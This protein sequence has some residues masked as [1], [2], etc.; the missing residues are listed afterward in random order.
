MFLNYG[1]GMYSSLKP[2]IKNLCCF[3]LLRTLPTESKNISSFCGP[4]L[5]R[6][7]LVFILSLEL[8]QF[9]K[10]CYIFFNDRLEVQ[11]TDICRSKERIKSHTNYGAGVY[12]RV[13]KPDFLYFL[14][15]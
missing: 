2:M 11:E 13:E 12:L 1:K 4:E 9:L 15:S 7:L 3:S 8:V 14:L 6:K 5:G 10:Y